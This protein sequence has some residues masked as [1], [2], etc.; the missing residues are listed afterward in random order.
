VASAS[1]VISSLAQEDLQVQKLVL[2]SS[3]VFSVLLEDTSFVQK[4]ISKY[5]FSL[6][7]IIVTLFDRL[8][9]GEQVSNL[10]YI[11]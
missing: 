7:Q 9:R 3:Q 5:F 2:L 10:L 1:P 4:I 6:E 11:L 8:D